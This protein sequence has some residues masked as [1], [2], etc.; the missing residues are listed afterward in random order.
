MAIEIEGVVVE[1]PV[2]KLAGTTML[3][4]IVLSPW[5]PL[6]AANV[7][8]GVLRVQIAMDLD[9]ADAWMSTLAP[10]D[11]VRFVLDAAI[12]AGEAFVQ[13]RDLREHS[14][15]DALAACRSDVVP[16]K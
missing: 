16:R 6:G 14:I 9:E 5:R 2:G 8:P 1:V 13:G 3:V 15:S 4:E 10:G 12:T 7:E 11:G